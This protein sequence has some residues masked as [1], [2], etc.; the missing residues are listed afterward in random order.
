MLESLL[1]EREPLLRH[2]IPR[3][4]KSQPYGEEILQ[5]KAWV[6]LLQT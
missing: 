1:I 6:H 3:F 4:G 2:T 5:P